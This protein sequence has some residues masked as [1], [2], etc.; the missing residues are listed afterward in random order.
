MTQASDVDADAIEIYGR[1]RPRVVRRAPRRGAR[2]RAR[3]RTFATRHELEEPR[4]RLL[5]ED[6]GATRVI[7]ALVHL[8]DKHP[9]IK[10]LATVLAYF[11]KNK[12]RMR[13]AEWKREG[14]MIGRGVDEAAC[15]T[16]VAQRPKLSGMRWDR[17][18]AQAILTMRGWDQSLRFDEAWALV[19]ATHQREVDVL[20]NVVD[21]TPPPRK[22]RSRASR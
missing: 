7:G 20:A 18:G 22:A 21:I 13:Y 17:N 9:R 16:L 14:F 8:R 1:V 10:K 2:G 4:E 6:D 12:H 3:R 15:K 11:R 5:L 19:A